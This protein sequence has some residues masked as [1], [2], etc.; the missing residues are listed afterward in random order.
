M[1]ARSILFTCLLIGVLLVAF[2]WISTAQAAIITVNTSVDE[3]DGSCSDGDCSLR[4]AIQLANPDDTINFSVTDVISLTLGELVINK[5]LTLQGPGYNNL[6]ISGNKMSRVF[7]INKD[8]TATIQ[9][10]TI[11]D[12]RAVGATNGG[13]ILNLGTLTLTR[14]IIAN[15]YAGGDGGGIYNHYDHGTLYV[16]QSEFIGN[17]AIYGGGIKNESATATITNSTFFGNVGSSRGGGMDN[18]AHS[19]Y[20]KSNV[21]IRNSTFYGNV[22]NG[23]ANPASNTLITNTII[24]VGGSSNCF[25]DFA[26]GSSN[27]L[28]TDDKCKPGFTQT[29][30]DALKM[31]RQG[32][33]FYLLSGSVAIDTGN[34]AVCPEIDQL[35][36]LRPQDGN[37]DGIFTCDVGSYEKP[38]IVF[39]NHLFLPI[40]LK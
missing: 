23:V 13:G 27:N 7:S 22:G 1:N 19:G 21:T 10:V 37:G 6:K 8:I 15:N 38:T 24:A 9:D 30:S 34:N 17:G 28:S 25:G 16:F 3:Q 36:A 12:G 35:G 40:T 31:L 32:W 4:D 5:N 39:S 33:V 18:G 29:T 26:V 14:C 2:G 20:L 11:S